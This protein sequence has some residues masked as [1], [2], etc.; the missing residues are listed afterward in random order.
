[1]E[2]NS[3][4]M[5]LKKVFLLSLLSDLTLN[6]YAKTEYKSQIKIQGIIKKPLKYFKYILEE[7]VKKFEHDVFEKYYLGYN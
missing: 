2:R 3:R 7:K 4:Q 1:M 5:F 6:V